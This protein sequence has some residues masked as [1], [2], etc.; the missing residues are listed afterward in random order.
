MIMGKP[1]IDIQVDDDTGRWSVDA[2]PMILVPQH[3]YLNNH[4]AIEKVLGAAEM[5]KVLRPA[6]YKSAYF[7]C[8]KEAAFHGLD[9]EQVFRHYLKRLSQR[10]WAQFEIEEMSPA[11]GTASIVVRNSAMI[12]PSHVREKRKCCYMFAGWFEGAFDYVAKSERRPLAF[13]ATE[14]YCTA[15]GQHDHCR[16]DVR[17]A[18]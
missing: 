5:E 1:Q 6:G 13:K 8:E 11:H 9:G 15:E 12:D 17:R 18:K 10:G 4:Y 2:L 7:W 3:F 14:V 16:F